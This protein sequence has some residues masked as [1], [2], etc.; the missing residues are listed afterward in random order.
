MP[1][2]KEITLPK[3]F[4][5]VSQEEHDVQF[6]RLEQMRK[7]HSVYRDDQL[8]MLLLIQDAR[9]LKTVSDSWKKEE[10]T[11]RELNGTLQKQVSALTKRLEKY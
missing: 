8:L 4:E 3:L 5:G 7:D 10:K 2:K 9:T 6:A 1:I 11:W